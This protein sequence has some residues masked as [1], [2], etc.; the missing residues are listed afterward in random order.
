MKK[1]MRKY[2][3]GVLMALACAVV[4][5]CGCVEKGVKMP[6]MEHGDLL[7]NVVPQNGTELAAAIADV[8]CDS[9]QLQISH[10]AIVCRKGDDVFALEATTKKGVVLTPID[11][12]MNH[13]DMTPDGKPYVVHARLKDTTGVAKCVERAERYLG[14]PYDSLYMP[15]DSAIYCSELV[16]LSFIDAS[17]SPI[18]ELIPMSFHDDTGKITD[19]WIEHYKQYN[20]PVPDGEPGTNP[21]GILRSEKIMIVE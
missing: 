12:F 3:Y 21:G 20:L 1:E 14:K 17:G 9:G 16:Q 18:F 6:E 8:T 7:F 4:M 13:A 19:F 10:V 2:V 11:S 15:D 5:L